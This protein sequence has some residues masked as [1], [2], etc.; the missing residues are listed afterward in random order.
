M[1]RIFTLIF[2]LSILLI[3]VNL[4]AQS[5]AERKEKYN[6]DDGIALK[7]Y[8]PVAYFTQKKAVKGSKNYAYTYKGVTYRFSSAKNRATF[9]AN[10]SKYEP[11][12]GGWCAY[13]LTTAPKKV[14]IDPDSFKII[15]GKLYLF[16]SNY[17]LGNTLKKWNAKKDDKKQISIANKNY[18]KLK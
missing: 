11:Q 14:D 4:F 5:S 15:N 2:T 16:Y 12:Y 1:K 8:D 7:G 3:Q 10:P 13:A 18:S 17:I 9:K 6:L